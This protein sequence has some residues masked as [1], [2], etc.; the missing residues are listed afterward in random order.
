MRTGNDAIRLVVSLATAL[1]MVPCLG[2]ARPQA[3]RPEIRPGMYDDTQVRSPVLWPPP[4]RVRLSRRRVDL[5][6]DGRRRCLVVIGDEADEKIVTGAR[7]ISRR[8]ADLNLLAVNLPIRRT[9]EMPRDEL[10]RWNLVVVGTGD[11]NPLL[12]DLNERRAKRLWKSNPRAQGY[13]LT[14]C[15]WGQGNRAVLI[16]GTDPLGA[17]YGCNTFEQL[18]AGDAGTVRAREAT[19]VDWPGFR[20]RVTGWGSEA[21]H[22]TNTAALRDYVAFLARL[23]FNLGIGGGCAKPDLTRYGETRG[24][25]QADGQRHRLPRQHRRRMVDPVPADVEEPL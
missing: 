5:V 12:V 16:H 13:V 18:L 8:V 15:R 24:L 17:L 21:Y 25:L 22:S 19:V 23:R 1:G 7:D 20:F 9:S 2:V 14:S 4:R 3:G 6:R 10:E 11:D